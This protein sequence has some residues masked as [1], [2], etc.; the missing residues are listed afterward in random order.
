MKKRQNSRKQLFKI[1]RAI[2][3][4][5]NKLKVCDDSD[6]EED[7]MDYLNDESNYLNDEKKRL[8]IEA[9]SIIEDKT[10]WKD[11]LVMKKSFQNSNFQNSNDEFHVDGLFQ[12]L[13]S[14]RDTNSSL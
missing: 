3:D 7:N 2:V 14:E 6:E 13:H 10:L 9:E 4:I 11:I 5:N 1:H 8:V 12:L